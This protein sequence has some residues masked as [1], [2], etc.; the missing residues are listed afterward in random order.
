MH[1]V[2]IILNKYIPFGKRYLAINLFGVVFAKGKL[3]RATVNHEYIHTLQQREM[4]FLF[5]FLWYILEWIF[6]VI[7]YR[8]FHKG[9]YNISFEREAYRNQNNL[10]YNQER[11][12]YSWVKYLKKGKSSR[13]SVPR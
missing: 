3:N 5:F 13:Q 6:R 11:K 8:S 4:A 2:K 7:Q 9:Y 1:V 10:L 12:R